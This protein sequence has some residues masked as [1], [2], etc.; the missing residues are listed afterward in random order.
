MQLS[1]SSG[2]IEILIDYES[3][4]TIKLKELIPDWWGA[5]QYPV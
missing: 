1:P 3:R 5:S 4:K 2:E